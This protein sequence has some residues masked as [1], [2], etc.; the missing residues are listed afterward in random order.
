M[1]GDGFSHVIDRLTTP[2]KFSDRAIPKKRSR[3]KTETNLAA[4]FKIS[5]NTYSQNKRKA[6]LPIQFIQLDR[7]ITT[8]FR[9]GTGSLGTDLCPR[10][11]WQPKAVDRKSIKK[12]RHE[13]HE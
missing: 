6:C 10:F 1:D 3:P 4:F 12:S 5:K 11:T 8:F 7:R 9:G 13:F 2:L